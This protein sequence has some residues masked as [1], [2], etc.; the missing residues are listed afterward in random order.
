[1]ISSL[2]L[3]LFDVTMKDFRVN[4]KQNQAVVLVDDV[5]DGNSL[6]LNSA[7]LILVYELINQLFTTR[8]KYIMLFAMHEAVV[9]R[10]GSTTMCILVLD[11]RQIP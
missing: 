9:I 2:F 5:S 7:G 10:R 6:I 11:I 3:R 8:K 4:I 1:M